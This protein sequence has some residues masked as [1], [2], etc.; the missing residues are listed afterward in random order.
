MAAREQTG[1][2]RGMALVILLGRGPKELV[3]VGREGAKLK[4]ENVL[5]IGLPAT[6]TWARL[7][8]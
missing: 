4:P 3:D 6:A 5:I 7:Y 2:I 1:N 8:A